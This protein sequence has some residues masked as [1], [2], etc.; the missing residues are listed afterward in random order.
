[1]ANA[2][3]RGLQQHI[4]DPSVTVIAAAT[5][6]GVT[7]VSDSTGSGTDFVK[8]VAAGKGLHYAGATTATDNE[9]VELCGNNLMFAAQEGHC[10]VEA[11][12]QTSTIGAHAF[13][14]GFNDT[15]EEGAVAMELATDTIAATATD[16]VGILYDADATNLDLYAVWVVGGTVGQTSAAGSVN[17][18]TI[19]LNGVTPTAAQWLY[20]KVELQDLG[21]GNG[22][23]ATFLAVDHNGKSFEKV[24]NIASWDR[25]LPL[26]YHLVFENRAA[27]VCTLFTKQNDW[28]QSIAG[29]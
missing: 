21:S 10:S 9:V 5:A 2:G 29:M 11:L 17:G 13:T 8:A 16:F 24:F 3:S 1:M 15:V 19:R 23:R 4:D 7:W 27:A 20:L 26:T 12:I 6:A 28:E 22:V 25:T 14:F 18:K